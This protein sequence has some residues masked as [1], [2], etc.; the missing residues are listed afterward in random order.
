MAGRGQFYDLAEPILTDGDPDKI[1]DAESYNMALAHDLERRQLSRTST[2][3]R[4]LAGTINI[5]NAKKRVKGRPRQ[6]RVSAQ[7]Q[8][9]RHA[10]QSFTKTVVD[11]VAEAKRAPFVGQ[12]AKPSGATDIKIDWSKVKRP[13][14][15]KSVADLPDDAPA[16]LK[17]II[18]HTGNLKE[19][20]EDL[21][22]LGML[23]EGLWVMVRRDA[24]DCRRL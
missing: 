18:G 2:A 17:H 1:K 24:R 8:R 19:L 20:N 22:Q 15:L 13:G 7:P 12:E 3:W 21:I 14:W 10:I 4:A 16:K 23:N 11:A 6:A 5:P 9:V